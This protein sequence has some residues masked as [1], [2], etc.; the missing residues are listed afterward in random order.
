MR[1]GSVDN[2]EILPSPMPIS[3]RLQPQKYIN[4]TKFSKAESPKKK[5]TFYRKSSQ[6][7]GNQKEQKNIETQ[8]LNVTMPK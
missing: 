6:I 2:I 7:I 3:R 8:K 1:T 4:L 5:Y